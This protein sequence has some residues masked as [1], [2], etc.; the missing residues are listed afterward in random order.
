[1]RVLDPKLTNPSTE[2]QTI[3]SR[4]RTLT[5]RYIPHQE[6]LQGEDI[7]EELAQILTVTRMSSDFSEA[8]ESVGSSA[9]VTE[10]KAI[11]EA[12]LQLDDIIKTKIASSD[13][14]VYVA[15]RCNLRRRED[16][17]RGRRGRDKSG[18]RASSCG[19]DDGNRAAPEVGQRGKGSSEAK[20]DSGEGFGRTPKTSAG[21]KW[22]LLGT[23]RR[24]GAVLH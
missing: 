16:G 19:G 9:D 12:T 18:R 14:T 20:S 22:H 17:E 8:M 10:V 4:W 7:M 3:A 5:K 2:G 11:I 1:M 15:P 24:L 21:S 13:M 6:P 23:Q